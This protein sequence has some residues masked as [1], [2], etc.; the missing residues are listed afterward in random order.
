M[1]FD[2]RYIL[3]LKNETI[4]AN[5]AT[6]LS[7]HAS[8]VRNT[9]LFVGKEEKN[10]PFVSSASPSFILRVDIVVTSCPLKLASYSNFVIL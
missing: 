4:L 9:V 5:L 3:C 1:P 6:L 7:Q 2:S 10:L 8:H